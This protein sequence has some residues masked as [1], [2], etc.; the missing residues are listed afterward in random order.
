MKALNAS[1]CCSGDVA[2]GVAIGEMI[3]LWT[4]RN[5]DQVVAPL[6]V[7][8]HVTRVDERVPVA[9][10]PGEAVPLGHLEEEAD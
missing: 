1:H 9:A 5:V 3:S 8:V 6:A 2:V 10:G 4:G 7:A